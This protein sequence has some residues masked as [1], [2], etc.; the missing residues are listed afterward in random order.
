MINSAHAPFLLA[1][2]S[3]LS[4]VV[5]LNSL[6]LM[7]QFMLRN[8]N[9]P[10]SIYVAFLGCCN[11]TILIFMLPSSI[12]DIVTDE[13][14]SEDAF[15]CFVVPYIQLFSICSNAFCMVAIVADLYRS[16][17]CS[18]RVG[19]NRKRYAIK[20]LTIV[21]FGAVLYSCRLFINMDDSDRSNLAVESTTERPEQAETTGYH[22]YPD[23]P[24]D[25]LSGNT[26]FIDF[27][28]STIIGE[29]GTSDLL[30]T[31]DPNV[32]EEEEHDED[33]DDDDERTCSIWVEDDPNDG[34][35]R[36][37]DATFLFIAPILIQIV[38]YAL[39][40]R[41]LWSS[42]VALGSA[43]R[44]HHTRTVVRMCVTV[45]TSFCLCWGP[46]H[47]TDLISDAVNRSGETPALDTFRQMVTLLAFSNSWTMPII[48]AMFNVRVRNQMFAI[49]TC[50]CRHGPGSRRDFR[51]TNQ[52][53]AIDVLTHDPARLNSDPVTI[54]NRKSLRKDLSSDTAGRQGD[55]SNSSGATSRPL[56]P[57]NPRKMSGLRRLRCSRS[58]S[59]PSPL[60]DFTSCETGGNGS[61]D[62]FT[63]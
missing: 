3:I 48:Y 26:V 37:V 14:S 15:R 28:G 16:V 27:H 40:G 39:V 34:Y 63:L 23:P 56:D 2:T 47:F 45:L 9:S 22:Y 59:S 46:W 49:L 61:P 36:L 7:S 17:C 55:A 31:G 50:R 60:P 41:K 30:P 32:T 4:V 25:F 57:H 11:I 42:N 21:S 51:K 35:S 43:A 18:A 8:Y 1:Y 58:R 29:L 38:L 53:I 24:Q 52:V 6:M 54:P 62:G 19:M 20:S 12:M 44:T 13:S 10:T 33:S 5:L